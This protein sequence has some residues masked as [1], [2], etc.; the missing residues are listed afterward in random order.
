MFAND[1][2]AP[3]NSKITIYKIKSPKGCFL[4]DYGIE[5]TTGAKIALWTWVEERGVPLHRKEHAEE[6]IKQLHTKNCKIVESELTLQ[7]LDFI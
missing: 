4:A 7:I 2:F 1:V 6:V 3:S 5:E